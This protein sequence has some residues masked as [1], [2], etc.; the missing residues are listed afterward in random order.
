L[1][2]NA[3]IDAVKTTGWKVA[4][5]RSVITAAA[6]WIAICAASAPELSPADPNPDLPTFLRQNFGL[7][8]DQIAAIRG[9]KPFAKTLASRTPAE[10][11]LFGAVYINAA[12]EAYYKFARDV[13]QT[14]KLPYTLALEPLSIPP[15]LSDFKD[16]SL[17]D[18]DV[19]ALKQCQTG[20]CAI[21]LP[22]SAIHDLQRSV[23]WSA[24][25]AG[26]Q[27]NLFL[28]KTALARVLAYQRQGD[29]ALG[30][31]N[32]HPD[33]VEV[34]QQFAYMLDYVKILPQRLPGF[35]HYLVSYPAAKPANVEN[36]FYWS[37]VKFGLKPTLRVVQVVSARGKP[38]DDIA[39]ATAEKQLYSSHYFET[40][41][42]LSLCVRGSSDPAHPGF[43]LV[44]AMGSEQAGLTGA[45]GSIIRYMAVGRSVSNLEDQL[46][47]IKTKLEA[48]R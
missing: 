25:D 17:D 9:G 19:Q 32:D 10:V 47:D 40:A 31:Y 43:Y 3:V 42:D 12:P 23:N 11:Y 28:Q 24:P 27:A 29:P 7:S 38:G 48:G 37:K 46:A 16:F 20:D 30:V 6:L 44:V 21:Q 8:D 39:Y 1:K 2:G 18:D 14:R 5:T 26:A 15:Q 45:K 35:Y 22:S 13:N 41:I 33:P 4:V 36:M 34:S